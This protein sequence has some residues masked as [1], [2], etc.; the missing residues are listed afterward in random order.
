AALA[1]DGKLP[2]GLDLSRIA[3]EPPREASHGDV[4]TNAALVLAGPAGSKPRT[5]ATLLAGHLLSTDGV[6]T[7]EVA[8]PGFINLRLSKAFWL[9]RLAEILEA[10]TG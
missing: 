2:P 3:V 10:G 7:A 9:A 4:A 5:L 6:E 1:A 8:G